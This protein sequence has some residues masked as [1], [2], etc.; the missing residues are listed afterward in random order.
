MSIVNGSG[1]SAVLVVSLVTLAGCTCNDPAPQTPAT[2]DVLTAPTP[3]PSAGRV[4]DR[5][6]PDEMPANRTRPD[7]IVFIVMDTVRGDHLSV[8]GYERPT[9]PVLQRLKKKGAQVSCEAYTPAP[10]TLP[11]HVSY[12]TGVPVPEHGSLFV[13]DSTISLTP[14]LQVR[15]LDERFDTLAEQLAG[16]GYQ[17]A[18]VSA[19]PILKED[20]G[21]LQGFDRHFTSEGDAI[22]RGKKVRKAMDSVLE[23]MDSE[24]PLFLFVNIYDAHDPY[25]K[26]PEGHS[27]LPKRSIFRMNSTAKDPSN[28]MYRYLKGMMKPEESERYLA[29]LLDTYDNGI[30]HADR[31]VGEV[32]MGLKSGGWLDGSYRLLVTTD[33]GEYLGEHQMLRHGCYVHQE[34]TGGFLVYQDTS[35]ESMPELPSPL[36][37]I[38][39]FYLARDGVLPEK[40]TVPQAI[41][42]PNPIFIEPGVSSGAIWANSEKVL[43]QEGKYSHYDLARDPGELSPSQLDENHELRPT[44]ED[45]ATRIK[46]LDELEAPTGDG[47][48]EA[49][50][51]VG[52]IE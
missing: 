20:A 34:V 15:P 43:W 9:S 33:H 2:P 29:A 21:V 42:E 45:L 38:D 41:S 5:A 23:P 19:N 49:L 17:T 48:N 25:P 3:V 30:S 37:L 51:A 24:K 8:C 36:S 1:M 52:Y 46:A 4:A 50:K 26:I 6:E 11:S 7:T 16:D 47:L 32:L 31:N 12:F 35:V 27:W 22:I 44:I 40:I 14:K 39:S 28:P 18:F 10:W 13:N